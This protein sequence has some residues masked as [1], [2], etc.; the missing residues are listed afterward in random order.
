MVEVDHLTRYYGN[1]MAIEDVTFSAQ[2]GSILGFL[3]PNAAGKTTTMRIMTGFLPPTRG[4]ARICGHDIVTD[5]INARRRLGYLPETAPL[6]EDMSV[7]G[8]LH[9]CAELRGVPPRD[10]PARIDYVMHAT[11]TTERADWLIAKLSKGF[12]RRVGLAQALV[13]DPE[14]LIL[15]EPTEGLDPI[16]IIEIRDLIRGLRTDE[17]TVILS[18]HILSEAQ[19]LAD[20]IV[21]IHRGRVVATDTPQKL[22][23]RLQERSR[24]AVQ[25]RAP[26]D[27]VRAALAAVSGVLDARVAETVDG[28][29]RLVVESHIERDVRAEL[30]AAVA[31]RGWP[32]LELE[33]VAMSLEEIFLATTDRD[34]SVRY[35]VPPRSVAPGTD[36]KDAPSPEETPPE[37]EDAAAPAA[38]AADAEDDE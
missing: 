12:R 19:A 1:T 7:R 33:T 6:Y 22:T 23:A 28:V 20:T 38:V 16:Q 15:D 32:L 17:R 36:G 9:F 27:E 29:A 11:H 13:H 37:E 5:S 31:A 34:E 3:G 24:V 21:I 30:A 18:T 25:V 26:A 35:V 2:Q 10:I 8:Y 14:V 4:T